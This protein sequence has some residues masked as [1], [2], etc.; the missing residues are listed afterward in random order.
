MKSNARSDRLDLARDLNERQQEAVTHGAGPLLVIAGAG[1]GKTRVITYRVA[2]LALN[3]GIDPRRIFAVTFTNKAAR[4]MRER[5]EALLG[6]GVD[7]WVSTF[8]AACARLLRRYGEQ[9]GV[10][11]RFTIYDDQDQKAMVARVIKEL[12]ID[13]RRFPPRAI[14]N[15][16]NRAKR[17]LV[18][19]QEYPRS[20]F[21]RERVA[22]IYELYEKRMADSSALDF[23]DLLYRVV[24][25]M[26]TDQ[27]LREEISGLFD[28]VL[29]DEFQD[30]NHVQLELVRQLAAPHKNICVVGD[31]DQS[32]YSWRGADITN[33]LG[34]EEI[35]PGAR[36]VT[37][38]RNYRSDGQIL[39]AAHGVVTKLVGRR[40]KELWTSNEEGERVAVIEAPD[41]REEA[42]L[43]SRAVRDLREDGFSL[44]AQAVFYRTNAQS[45]VFE[46][47][48]RSL[49][50]PH[51][52][53]GGMRFYERAEVKDAVAYL[54][55]I[56][57][58]ADLAAF[59]RVVNTPTRGIGKTTV[60]RLVAIAAGAGISA[61]EA[62][63]RAVA[64]GI[65]SGPAKKLVAFRDLV[66]AWR[67]EIDE[68]PTHLAGRVLDD[69]GFLQRLEADNSAEA[70]AR[71]ENLKELLGSIADFESE[72]ETPT[73]DTFLELIALQTDVDLA[74][75]DEDQI[76]LM[77]VHAAKGLEFDVVFTTGME[78][79]LFPYRSAEDDVMG[80]ADSE[81][82]EERRLCYVAMTR[83]RKRRC[84]EHQYKNGCNCLQRLD[85]QVTE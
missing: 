84:D 70:D 27:A 63:G 11:P 51:R 21:Y 50:I 52:V 69:T 2:N 60:D 35:F 54:R 5:V 49:N 64:G 19:P 24:R 33:I 80:T 14:Q 16:I 85:E 34:F 26:Q 13:D 75:F 1:S 29:V 20:D 25:G 82:A 28:H 73:L 9:A 77:T 68:G 79:G 59:L 40:P 62:I 66:D 36:I 61:Y 38:D 45:R 72:A 12:S 41:E 23:A 7:C 4:E 22:S 78:D 53:L 31:D 74:N 67:G 57:N 37:L 39:K 8:H 44:S 55:L 48:F 65:S 32:I 83:A 47:V 10:D 6:H 46:E 18:V 3:H 71:I 58:P 15:E 30:T 56:Q 42:R 76:T 43:V 17:E 81:M